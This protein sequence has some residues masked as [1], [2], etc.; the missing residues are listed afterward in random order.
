MKKINILILML[1]WV[2]ALSAQNAQSVPDP[3]VGTWKLDTSQSQ[4]HNP[5]PQQQTVQIQSVTQGAIQYTISGTDAQGK[6]VLESFDGKADGQAYPISVNGVEGGRMSYQRVSDRE[7]TAQG[8]TQDGSTV[9]STVTLSPDGNTI[10]VKSHVTSSTGTYDDT[11]V[12]V[13]QQR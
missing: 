12:F 5:A 4:F 6:P 7:Y 2:I 1:G 10:T 9:T 3:W 11:A 13:K 8:T